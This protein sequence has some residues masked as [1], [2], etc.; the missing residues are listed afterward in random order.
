MCIITVLWEIPAEGNDMDYDTLFLAKDIVIALLTFAVIWA[1]LKIRA[2]KATLAQEKRKRTMPLITLEVNTGDDL[3]IFLV[4]DSYCYAKHIRMDDLDVT[5][6]Y[7]FKKRITLKFAPLEVL[8]PNGRIKLSYRV[9]DGQYDVTASDALNILNH[10]S[11]SPVEMRLRYEN[12]EGSPFAA[13][14][15]PEKGQ[16]IIK[17]VT[18]LQK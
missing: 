12:I 4:N 3:G 10:F 18:P 9:F 7:G 17:E 5:V 16:Y 11:D 2:L 14:V 15:A 1:A 8:K 13:T 6:D